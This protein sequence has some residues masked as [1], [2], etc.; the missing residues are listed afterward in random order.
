MIEIERRKSMKTKKNNIPVGAMCSDA[1]IEAL[2]NTL[3]SGE[4]MEFNEDGTLSAK[5]AD[6]KKN[7][8][9]KGDIP[10]GV[11]GAFSL[12]DILGNDDDQQDDDSGNQSDEESRPGPD[13]RGKKKLGDIPP[14]VLGSDQWY[15][16]PE[17]Q[18]QLQFEMKSMEPFVGKP[19]WGVNCGTLEDGRMYWLVGQRIKAD[20]KNGRGSLYDRTYEILLVYQPN[21]PQGEWGTSVHAYLRAPHDLNEMRRRVNS[22]M[23]TPKNIPHVLTDVNGMQ[24]LCTAHQNDFG[25]TFTDPR[26]VPTAKTSLLA[27]IKWLHNFE[28]G[29]L[30]QKHWEL[31]QKHGIL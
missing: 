6:E 10:G 7:V 8:K 13:E 11:L 17:N 24:Y 28:C 1:D 19:K 26:G 20:R 18:Q 31:F 29:L 15:T 16:K 3:E 14:G 22:S 5:G 23:R 27:A 2:R 30:S 4:P 9:K 25:T 21:H 12:K